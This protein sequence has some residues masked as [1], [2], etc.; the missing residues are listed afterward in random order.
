M[1]DYSGRSGG[2]HRQGGR[3]GFRFVLLLLALAFLA[4]AVVSARLYFGGGSAA[5][6]AAATTPAHPAS[7]TATPSPSKT[8]TSPFAGL[9]GYLAGRSGRITA[10]VYD[11]RTGRTWVLNPGIQEDTASI[12]KVQIMGTALRQA[13]TAGTALPPGRAALMLPMIE[14]SDN[15]A[16]TTLLAQV[17]GPSAVKSFDRSAGLLQTTPS[18]LALIPGTQW[19]GWGLTTTTAQDQVTLVSRFAYPNAMLTSA[20]RL[21]GLNLMEHVEADQSW[22][23]SAGVAAGT[24]VALKNGWI[25]LAGSGWQINSVGWVSG[26]GRNYVLA[27]L[28]SGNPTEAYGISTIETISRAMFAELGL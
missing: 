18:T 23:V 2:R 20:D 15:Q 22:G 1:Q 25:D 3:R 6:P 5:P 26:N 12:V 19:P 7:A 9:S 4:V 16:A 21:Y 14:N 24:T 17:G 27:V 11:A 8:A 28:T 13:E 10:A